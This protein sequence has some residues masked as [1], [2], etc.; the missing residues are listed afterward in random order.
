M[1]RSDGAHEAQQTVPPK[2]G[3]VRD[4]VDPLVAL[5][6]SGDRALERLVARLLGGPVI[7]HFNGRLVE[8][9]VVVS[10][11]SDRLPSGPTPKDSP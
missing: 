2:L 6:C 4:D 10:T 11:T 7:A 3:R 9:A 5:W 8:A 1:Q